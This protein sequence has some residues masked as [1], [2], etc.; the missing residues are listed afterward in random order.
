MELFPEYIKNHDVILQFLPC[1]LGNN[2]HIN[3]ELGI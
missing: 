3:L 2:T 1:L